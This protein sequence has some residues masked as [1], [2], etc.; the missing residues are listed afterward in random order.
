MSVRI[1]GGIHKGMV[2]STPDKIRP[3]AVSLKRKI[4]DSIQNL[5]GINFIDLCAGSGAMGFEA[6]SRGAFEVWLVE[7]HSIAYRVL[8]KNKAKINSSHL[9][10]IKNCCL[11]WMPFFLKSYIHWNERK[12][13]NTIIFL[14]PPYGKKALYHQ[15]TSLLVKARFKGQIWLESH[16]KKGIPLSHWK[17]HKNPSLVKSY[18]KG[19][20]H[21]AIFLVNM[22]D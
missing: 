20:G 15:I 19:D 12:K 13:K 2:V 3:T 22:S 4:F 6:W 9:H 11:K 21:I 16:E 17:E 1:L 5:H 14:D 18:H 10:L 8:K 7:S